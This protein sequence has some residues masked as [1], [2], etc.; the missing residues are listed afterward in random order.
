VLAAGS[1]ALFAVALVD[2]AKKRREP[3]A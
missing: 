1:L 3:E 2:F